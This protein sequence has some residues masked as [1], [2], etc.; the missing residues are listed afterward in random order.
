MDGMMGRCGGCN[1]LHRRSDE[2]TADMLSP[3]TLLPKADVVTHHSFLRI[4]SFAQKREND[5]DLLD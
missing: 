1:G 4:L 5:I 3:D 2:A